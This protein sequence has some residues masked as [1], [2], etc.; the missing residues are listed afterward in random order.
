MKW[1]LMLYAH[2]G[3][4]LLKQVDKIAST[5]AFPHFAPLPTHPPAARRRGSRHTCPG[6]LLPLLRGKVLHLGAGGHLDRKRNRIEVYLAFSA[7]SSI[8]R[9]ARSNCFE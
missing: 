2:S 7:I 9:S 3:G 8:S 4:I 5:L 6:I 1:R